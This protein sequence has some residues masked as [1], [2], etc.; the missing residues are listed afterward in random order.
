MLLAISLPVGVL[1]NRMTGGV[2]NLSGS[3]LIMMGWLHEPTLLQR[4]SA[5]LLSHL[6]APAVVVFLLLKLTR[7]G[8]WLAPNW[9]ALGCFLSLMRLLSAW[10][11]AACF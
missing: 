1:L 6:V 3:I 10:H 11:C 7:L 8:N 4:H 5:S 9:L 2:E